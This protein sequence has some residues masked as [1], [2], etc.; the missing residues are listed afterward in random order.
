MKK[1]ALI[2]GAT[3]LIGRQLVDQLAGSEH[4]NEVVTLTRR[5][6]H[7]P[8]AKVRNEVVDFERLPD[9][10]HL[11]QADLLFSCLGTTRSQA[12]SLQAQRKVDTAVGGGQGKR[13]RHAAI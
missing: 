9:F 6:A 11:L 5:P 1:T 3:G 7:H 2:I 13:G 10:A 8:S 4:V 12:G